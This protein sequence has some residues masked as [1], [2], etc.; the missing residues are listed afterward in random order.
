MDDMIERVAKLIA[1]Q[2]AARSG[3][4]PKTADQFADAAWRDY[5]ADARS[6]V[7]AMCRPTRA[8]INAGDLARHRGFDVFTVYGRMMDSALDDRSA[9]APV[10]AVAI[11]N[12]PD[13]VAQTLSDGF[14]A[15]AHGIALEQGR[16][17]EPM[18]P[19]SKSWT[20]I[21]D[22]IAEMDQKSMPGAT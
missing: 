15:R 8:M 1:C 22:R 17:A 11:L 20:A 14:G 19:A 13:A 16:L 4:D 5:E 3:K 6:I 21:A 2:A 10:P 12:S 9:A 18:G 7:A